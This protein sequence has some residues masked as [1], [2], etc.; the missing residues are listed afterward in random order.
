M[1]GALTAKN[2]PEAGRLLQIDEFKK[3]AAF[4]IPRP[5]QLSTQH[6]QTGRGAEARPFDAS[7]RKSPPH[8]DAQNLRG[9]ENLL[10]A[11]V[12]GNPIWIV[13]RDDGQIGGIQAEIR[14]QASCK[15]EAISFRWQSWGAPIK[16][17]GGLFHHGSAEAPIREPQRPI[18]AS[19]NR[20]IVTRPSSG[21]RKDCSD[22]P[23]I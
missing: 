20:S 5:R 18:M 2:E 6:S 10:V 1:T 3:T 16:T 12:E 21:T 22:L 15:L 11:I 7:F 4:R 14:F 8:Q 23:P 17:N 9:S 19:C 13:M